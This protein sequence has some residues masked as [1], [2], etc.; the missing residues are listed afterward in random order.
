MQK[1]WKF[2]TGIFLIVISTLL[3][4]SL[5]VVPFLGVNGKTKITITTVI[6]VLGEV[7]FWIGGFLLGKELLIKY[8]SYLNPRNWFKKKTIHV[9]IEDSKSRENSANQPVKF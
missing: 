2:K 9:P 4:M 5:L 8:K 1:N 3:F 7:T 6:I